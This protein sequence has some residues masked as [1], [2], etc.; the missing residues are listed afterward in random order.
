M[1]IEFCS[2][3][4]T[5]PSQLAKARAKNKNQPEAENQAPRGEMILKSIDV[6]FL[7]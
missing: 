3:K 6:A 4:F 5:K 1:T 2:Y 7:D